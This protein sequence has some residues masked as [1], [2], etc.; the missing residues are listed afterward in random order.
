MAEPISS[1]TPQRP[2]PES[3]I[4]PEKSE[5][6]AL[7]QPSVV[8]EK[9]IQKPKPTSVTPTMPAPAAPVAP[10]PV[11]EEVKSET[12]EAIEDIME[13]DLSE[14]YTTMPPQAKKEFRKK[15]EET[16]V[17]IEGLMY[18][19]KVKSKKIFKLLFSWLKIIP[20]VNKYFLEQ[21]AKLKTDEIMH[22]K[23]DIN[24]GQQNKM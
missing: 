7:E 10:L 8:Q 17:E 9:P 22:I 3:G 12:L 13:E 18:K 21:E 15:G 14:M 16:A 1:D 20:G 4:T 23:E 2:T 24:K 5:G 6:K 11:S 19:V